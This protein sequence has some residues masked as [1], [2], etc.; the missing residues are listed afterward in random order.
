MKKTIVLIIFTVCAMLSG[1]AQT[2]VS[3]NILT[4][5][6]LNG[7]PASPGTN[8]STPVV[9]GYISYRYN[10]NFV[11]NQGG[12]LGTNSAVFNILVGASTNP[13]SDAVLGTLTF[14]A[15]N[16]ASLNFQLSSYQQPIYGIVQSVVTNNTLIWHQFVNTPP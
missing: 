14:P 1:R 12:L 3:T 10:P 16:A 9:I 4:P 13:A 15:T 6:T 5:V 11:V 8:Y 7:T 2:A